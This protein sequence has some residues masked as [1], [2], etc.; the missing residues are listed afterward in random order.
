[1]GDSA[2]P[3][4]SSA[5]R[6]NSPRVEL[7]ENLGGGLVRWTF[8]VPVTIAG[9]FP[10]NGDGLQVKPAAL[11]LSPTTVSSGTG[12]TRFAGYA[13]AIPAGSPW[14]TVLPVTGL[15]PALPD[16]QSGVVV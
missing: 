2:H 9:L 7:V 14:R 12:I 3:F 5:L 6:L 10:P 8:D 15:T 4:G 16:A 11:W 1:M 13:Q